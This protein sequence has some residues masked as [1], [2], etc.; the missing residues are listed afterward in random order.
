MRIWTIEPFARGKSGY[1]CYDEINYAIVGL[2]RDAYTSCSDS[3][4]LLDLGCG[5]GRLGLELEGLGYKVT[6][7]DNSP[8][9]CSAARQRISEVIELDLTDY[10]RVEQ[11]LDGRRFDWLLAADSLEHTI[12][13]WAVLTFYR[14]FLKPNGHL[15]LSLPNPVV[16]DNRIRMLFGR[17]DYADSGIMD[18]THVRFFTFRSA[19]QLVVN[20]GFVP[21]KCTWEPGIARAFLPLIKRFMRNREQSPGLIIES[22]AYGFYRQWLMPI[23][24]TVTAI[25]PNLFAFRTVILARPSV[26]Y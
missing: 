9:A 3:T 10:G 14:Q 15:V 26:S 12:D 23:E 25:A 21:E 5:R 18:R 24:R 22:E 19:R 1:Y 2:L 17:F 6:G 11:C 4:S 7:L 8:I 13:P 20:C 16:W